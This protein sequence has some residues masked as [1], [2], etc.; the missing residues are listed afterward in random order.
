MDNI[1]VDY[2]IHDIADEPFYNDTTKL[3]MVNK[4]YVEPFNIYNK[5]SITA[6]DVQLGF[7]MALDFNGTSESSYPLML[8]PAPFE[9]HV[10]KG[11]YQGNVYIM[12]N[13]HNVTLHRT[14]DVTKSSGDTLNDTTWDTV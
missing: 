14:E 3:W 5:V 2:A 9:I 6:F 8:P 10:R 7:S 1:T 12:D 11:E 4:I 13:N